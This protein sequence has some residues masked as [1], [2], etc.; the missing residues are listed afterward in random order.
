MRKSPFFV[1]EMFTEREG[2][3]YEHYNEKNAATD[4]S[5]SLR[6]T[7]GITEKQN[8]FHHGQTYRRTYISGL[9]FLFKST[10]ERWAFTNMSLNLGTTFRITKDPPMDKITL[11][12]NIVHI[13]VS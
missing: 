6:S 2:N 13:S 9:F 7:Y 5:C 11:T 8:F 12:A 10:P 1:K 3:E 4:D